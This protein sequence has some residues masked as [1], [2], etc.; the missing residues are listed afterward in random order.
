[1]ERNRAIDEGVFA[2]TKDPRFP[3]ALPAKEMVPPFL[4]FAP[5]EN[6]LARL[7]RTAQQYDRALAKA[8]AE[9]RQPRL[10]ARRCGM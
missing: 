10:R 9:W 1:M 7:Q 5:L 4:N 6:G 2:A 8:A 3:T